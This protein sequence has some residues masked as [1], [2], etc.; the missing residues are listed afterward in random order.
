LV[1]NKTDEPIQRDAQ[2]QSTRLSLQRPLDR[3]QEISL[4]SQVFQPFGFA[5]P[6]P[7]RLW[8]K[9][10]LL[11]A[12]ESDRTIVAGRVPRLLGCFVHL[13]PQFDTGGGT[14]T[15]EPIL[16]INFRSKVFRSV[17]VS[18]KE[19]R[20]NYSLRCGLGLINLYDKR[21]KPACWNVNLAP[22][23]RRRA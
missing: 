11:P 22:L 8:M 13:N 14:V 21:P 4:G 7:A 18:C 17:A 9:D 10:G 1:P 20:W 16:W 23:L 5:Q 2:A 19:P 15:L 12:D 3:I 6:A